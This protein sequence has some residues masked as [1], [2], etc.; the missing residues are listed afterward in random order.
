MQPNSVS[1]ASAAQNNAKKR[2]ADPY[3]KRIH[4]L[5]R[6]ARR[7]MYVLACLVLTFLIAL[8]IRERYVK[9]PKPE[10]LSEY[11]ENGTFFNGITIGGKN[12]A[13]M[14]IEEARALLLPMVEQ[15]ANSINI[16]V[17]YNSSIWVFTAADMN[18]TSDIDTVLAEAMLYGRSGTGY[19][20]GKAVK[21]SKEEGQA[22][23]ITLLPDTGLLTGRLSE[24]G[25]AIDTPPMEPTAEPDVWAE[26]PAFEY[27]E[28][29]N[30]YML[31]ES[32]LKDAI[33]ACL[34]S[35]DY[36]AILTPELKLTSPERDLSWLKENTQL[37]ATWQTSFGGS[38]SLHNVNRVG[39]IQKATTL[40][41]GCM[42]EDG[43]EFN[44]NAFIGPRTERGGWPLAPGIV[45]GNTYQMEPGGGICQVSTTLYNALL[46]CGSETEI[47]ERY[48]HSWPS[49]YAD[50]GLD[51]TVTGT[52]QSGKSLNFINNTGAP[53]YIFAY[54]DQKDY[55]MTIYIYGKPLEDGITYNLRSEIVETLTPATPTT[56]EN[57]EW[58]AGYQK[59]T[60]TTRNGYVADVY[61]EQYVNDEI[62]SSTLLYTD[63]YRAIQGEITVGTGDPSL[64]KPS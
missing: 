51:A 30:G 39:N 43:E 12:V 28:G 40:L 31:D 2:H 13:G 54:C 22:F 17:S 50:V 36:Q 38:S 1:S 15:E 58:P 20:N 52:A 60:I 14:T 5:R 26:M 34:A 27:A 16:V 25:S 19:Q 32:A 8:F 59:K 21:A 6:T 23:A 48:H 47:T 7:I 56:I 18:V 44:F 29:E 41:N 24:I 46:R 10:V 61:R 45:N 64:P 11:L 35:G 53:L 33:A 49:S 37:R 63:T 57:P 55:T 3:K 42:V 62:K 4:R 9:L